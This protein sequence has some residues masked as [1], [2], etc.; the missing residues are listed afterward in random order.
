MDRF[1]KVMMGSIIGVM[2]LALFILYMYFA[3]IYKLTQCDFKA[4]YKCEIA[5]AIWI[6][7]PLHIWTYW[8]WTDE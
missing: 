7:P 1:D 5:H 2:L 8:A 6:F 3:N 4:D